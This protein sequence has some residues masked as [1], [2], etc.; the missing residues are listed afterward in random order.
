MVAGMRRLRLAP[1]L[2]APLVACGEDEPTPVGRTP[3]PPATTGASTGPVLTSDDSTTAATPCAC[4]PDQFCAAEYVPGDPEPEPGAFGCLDECVAPGAPGY[5]CH[6]QAPSCCAGT[7]CDA[8]GLCAPVAET[9]GTS[10]TGAGTTDATAGTTDTGA[11]TTDATAGTT[12]ATAGT[13]AATTS[14]G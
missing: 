13:T 5:W 1:F 3:P 11:G 2:L 8:D 6:D 14:T 12:D 9:D 10:T 4:G 7:I